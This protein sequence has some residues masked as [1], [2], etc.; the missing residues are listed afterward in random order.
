MKFLQ[1]LLLGAAALVAAQPHNHAHKHA[2]RHG[3]PLDRRDDG[4]TTT[5]VPGPVTTVY[6]LDGKDVP[7]TEVEQGL[8]NGR[9][10]L[11]GETISNVVA[12]STTSSSSSSSSTST[13]SISSSSSQAAQFLQKTSTS[14]TPTSTYVPPTTSTTPTPTPTPTPSSTKEAVVESTSVAVPSSSSSPSSG[15]SSGGSG[16][17]REFPSGQID[18][19]DFPSDYGAVP[20]NW[21]GLNGYTGVQMVPGFAGLAAAAI[22]YIETAISGTHN[23]CGPNSFCSYACPAGYQKSQWPTAQGSTGQSIGGLFCNSH[24]KLELSRPSYKTL[25][26]EGAGGVEVQNKLSSNVAICRTDYPGTESE[27]VALDLTP[28]STQPICNPDAST[29]YTWE[30]SSTSAQ[31]YINPAGVSKEDACQ[32][33]TKGSNAGNWAPTNMGVGKN[34]AGETFISLF[35]NAPTNPDGKLNFNIDITGGVSG[36]CQY[37][38]GKYYSNGVESATGCTVSSYHKSGLE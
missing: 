5:T 22:S 18:C 28:G 31:Y 10:V 12:P 2:A 7:W 14:T 32:W 9:F 23:A 1:L 25:C 11:V 15:S 29:Y 4:V 8:A 30:G 34:A 38:N 35:Q 19:S 17:D 3:S 20:A 26:Q 24:G 6:E 33:G 36:K 13:V 27:T 37:K 16:V 21:L